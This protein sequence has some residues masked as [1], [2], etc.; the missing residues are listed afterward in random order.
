M[1]INLGLKCRDFEQ[2]SHLFVSRIDGL[3][4]WSI[5]CSHLDIYVQNGDLTFHQF[6]VILNVL[7]CEG[8]HNTSKSFLVQIAMKMLWKSHPTDR[9]YNSWS[10]IARHLI[11]LTTDHHNFL[12][13]QGPTLLGAILDIVDNPHDSIPIGRMFLDILLELDFDIVEYLQVEYK[14]HFEPSRSLP[15]LHDSRHTYYRQRDLIICE[16]PPSVSWEWYIDPKEVHL[17]SST[18]SRALH[19]PTGM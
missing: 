3:T 8:T 14:Q 18:N 5:L 11:S 12:N 9:D 19:L 16:T 10:Q 2:I 6:T 4:P 17:I 7:G 13:R 15:M 1:V